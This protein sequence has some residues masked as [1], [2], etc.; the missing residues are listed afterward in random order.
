MIM[1]IIKILFSHVS[2]SAP[3]GLKIEGSLML[4]VPAVAA[5]I[6]GFFASLRWVYKDA[7]R[8][9]KPGLVFLPLLFVACWPTSLLLWLWLRPPV[10]HPEPP[11]A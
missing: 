3:G 6:Y 2:F 1:H 7:I 10:A 9:A 4:V 11:A 8:R 5:A